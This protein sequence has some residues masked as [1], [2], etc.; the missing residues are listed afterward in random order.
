[1]S[2]DVQEKIRKT[3][4]DNDVV[5]YIKGTPV[6]PQCGFSSTVVQIFDYLGVNYESVN[7]LEN[8]DIRQG[9]KDYNNWPTI[10][11]I[12]V[13]GEFIGGCDIMREMFETGELK[14]FLA[15]K[16]IPLSA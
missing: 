10:P 12:F 2:S 1:M 3:V 9:I 14:T 16:E 7:V 13:K 5:L 8:Q 15:K 11:Q 4:T 6:F